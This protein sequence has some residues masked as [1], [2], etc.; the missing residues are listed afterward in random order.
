[1]LTE[2]EPGL[3]F[4]YKYSYYPEEREVIFNINSIFK[5]KDCK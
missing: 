4:I 3:A 2:H 5:I 1:M